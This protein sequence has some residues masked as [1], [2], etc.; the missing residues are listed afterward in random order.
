M[1][2]S[3]QTVRGKKKKKSVPLY[4]STIVIFLYNVWKPK[5]TQEDPILYF[6]VLCNDWRIETIMIIMIL[7]LFMLILTKM[8]IMIMIL[9]M[10]IKMKLMVIVTIVMIVILLQNFY[11]L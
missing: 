6:Q 9:A 3:H 4:C 8:M 2:E 10:I 1:I 11:F 5:G 7:I